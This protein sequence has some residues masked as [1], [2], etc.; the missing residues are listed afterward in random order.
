[1]WRKLTECP[2]CGAAVYRQFD[3]EN[4]ERDEPNWATRWECSHP[5][6]VDMS[7]LIRRAKSQDPLCFVG[8]QKVERRETL[9]LAAR[10]TGVIIY[11]NDT[12]TQIKDGLPYKSD[13]PGYFGVWSEKRDLSAFWNKVDELESI[14]ITHPTL[15]DF[16]VWLEA[17]SGNSVGYPGNSEF[18]PFAK[19]IWEKRPPALQG[20]SVT[21]VDIRYTFDP[22][23][24]TGLVGQACNWKAIV[25]ERWAKTFVEYVDDK[26][27]EDGLELLGS[28]A[29]EI[30]NN[31]TRES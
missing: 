14:Q 20:V 8:N 26:H 16:R 25:L 13:Q 27:D 1:M 12:P 4:P 3:E 5:E 11:L 28:E 2:K 17:N 6:A 10:L 24:V 7:R 23:M 15:E 21:D 22:T 19:Y 30:L 9:E 29:L 31:V 18:C